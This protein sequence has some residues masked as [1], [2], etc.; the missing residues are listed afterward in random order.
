MRDRLVASASGSLAVRALAEGRGGIMI[1]IQGGRAV[2]VPLRNV[3]AN[4]HPAPD[5]E[6]LRLALELA[7]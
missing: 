5:T 2:E 1:G 6:L 7:G 4:A 3:V